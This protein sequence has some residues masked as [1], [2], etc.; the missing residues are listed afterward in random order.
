MTAEPSTCYRAVRLPG[1]HVAAWPTITELEIRLRFTHRK[2]FP[3][4]HGGVIHGLLCQLFGHDLPPGLLPWTPESGRIRYDAGDSYV[5]SLALVGEARRLEA[6]LEPALQRLAAQPAPKGPR[7]I[8]GGNFLVESVERRS[9]GFGF[10]LAGSLVDPPDEPL[11]VRFL[12]PLRLKR[13]KESR[14]RG[15]GFVDSTY[16]PADHFL[17]RLY[18]RW[19]VLS[20]GDYPPARSV[21]EPPPEARVRLGPLPWVDLPVRGT[22]PR[23]RLT[24]GGVQGRV[25]FTGLTAPW[26]RLLVLMQSLHAGASTHYGLGRYVVEPLHLDPT[27]FDPAAP[28]RRHLDP[29]AS[30][31]S[32]AQAVDREAR[33]GPAG[34]DGVEPAEL[35]AGGAA[36]L[37]VLED[38]LK[39]GRYQPEPLRLLGDRAVPTVRDRVVQ[40]ALVTQLEQPLEVLQRNRTRRRVEPWTACEL[41]ALF[42]GEPAIDLLG[43]FLACKVY[44]RG[45]FL[46]RPHDLEVVSPLTELLGSCWPA[47]NGEVGSLIEDSKVSIH[48]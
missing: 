25:T 36:Q 4:H 7:R 42:P 45:R 44:Y 21:P 37:D 26:C 39:S 19:H 27:P 33:R 13:Q 5:F 34:L 31:R 17:R 2:Q 18:Q 14:R 1:G 47:L 43:S 20:T 24:L 11:A 16:F 46:P 29:L 23:R 30:R 32:L 6:Q 3:F 38:E 28:S 40:R 15:G 9:T 41:A 10:E 12:S 8:L 35:L 48:P 22:D